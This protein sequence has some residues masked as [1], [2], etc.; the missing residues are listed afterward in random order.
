M[1]TSSEIRK[2]AQ[3]HKVELE[4]VCHGVTKAL[5]EVGYAILAGKRDCGAL[6]RWRQ[7]VQR[8]QDAIEALDMLAASAEHGEIFR[9]SQGLAET[10]NRVK[11]RVA[12]LDAD[13]VEKSRPP[14]F[15]GHDALV[16]AQNAH[17]AALAEQSE[18][19]AHLQANGRRMLEIEGKY[20]HLAASEML[21]KRAS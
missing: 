13:V 1:L 3:D 5:H 15:S 20:P 11:E 18:I 16:E 6:D 19:E 7:L 12:Q 4:K 9:E 8:E 2:L 17:Q 14:C 21:T 10:L